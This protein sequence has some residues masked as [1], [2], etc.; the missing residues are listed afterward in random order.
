M[1]KIF[2]ITVK[3]LIPTD[4]LAWD[5]NNPHL[6]GDHIISADTEEE[7][8]D[9]FHSTIPIKVLDDFEITAKEKSASFNFSLYGDSGSHISFEDL[10]KETEC[11]VRIEDS[12]SEGSYIEV[13]KWNETDEVWQRFCFGKFLGGEIEDMD[14]LPIAK[15]IRDQLEKDWGYGSLVHNL[16]N[17]TGE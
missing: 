4:K 17:Y 3:Q 10:L 14:A 7:A 6:A 15:M 12:G 1:N 2:I 5:D 16:D 8:L 11:L 9:L 13:A